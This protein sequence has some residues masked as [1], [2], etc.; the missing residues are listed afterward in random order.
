[1]SIIITFSD[2]KSF[3]AIA[4]YGRTELVNSFSDLIAKTD[5]EIMEIHFNSAEVNMVD[6]QEYYINPDEKMGVI[7]ITDEGGNNFVYTDYIIPM[8]FGMEY[9]GEDTNPHIILAFAQLNE[10]DKT[11]RDVAQTR[12]VYTGTELEI[13]VA[14][15]ID[16]LSK[17]CNKAIEAGIDYNDEH[18]SL[19]S[20]D[21]TN[22]LAW[23][24]VANTGKAVPYHAD[25]SHC[26][27][28]TSEEFIGLSNT[29]IGHIAHHTTYCN[30]LMRWVETLTNIDEINSVKYGVTELTGIYLEE[31]N[32]NMALL[33]A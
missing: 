25:G 28:Y 3:K 7:T 22:I 6:L 18:Y 4:A 21:Q 1:M 29:A 2:N 27:T 11:L 31:Y 9:I 30:L 8:K 14:K 24:S 23:T 10:T 19:T 17:T 16:E 26:R 15:K 32:E 13:A 20:Q 33:T 12:K 5:R